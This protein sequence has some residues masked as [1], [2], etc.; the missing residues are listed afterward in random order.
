MERRP[1]FEMGL[2]GGAGGDAVEFRLTL[3]RVALCLSSCVVQ[4]HKWKPN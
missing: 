3:S 1:S 2:L 4:L